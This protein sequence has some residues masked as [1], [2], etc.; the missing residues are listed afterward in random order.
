[1]NMQEFITKLKKHKSILCFDYGSARLGVAVSDLLLI[2][3]NNYKT[4]YRKNLEKDIIEIKKIIEEKEVGAIL[5]GLPLQM[6]GSQGEMAAIVKDFASKIFA[7]TQLPYTFWDE[8]LSS[9]AAESFL[10]KQVDMNRKRRKEVLDQ[11]S[12]TFVLQGF[13]DHLRHIK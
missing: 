6:D 7:E 13:L 2:S 5:Y 9:Q 8:R 3:A 1:M 4:I 12:A 11:S 10:I